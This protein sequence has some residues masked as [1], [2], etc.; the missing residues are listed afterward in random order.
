MPSKADV[1]NAR[2]TR[3]DGSQAFQENVLKMFLC[4]FVQLVLPG[5]II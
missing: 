1:L 5:M 2:L 4:E 3:T